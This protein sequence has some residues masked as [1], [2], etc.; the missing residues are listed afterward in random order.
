[1]RIRGSRPSGAGALLA[2]A[3]CAACLFVAAWPVPAAAQADRRAS[4][5]YP[6]DAFLIEYALDHPAQP[7][8][9][10]LEALEVELRVAT[11]G[12]LPPHPATRNERFPLGRV[13]P[14]SRFYSAG[15]TYVAR[16]ILAEFTRRGIDGVLVTFP[17][18]EE[19]SGRD[20][21]AQG[22]RA[23]RVRIWTGRVESVATVAD[24]DRFGDADIEV[25]TNN[26]AH[27]FIREGSPVQ[28]G[29]PKGLLR[30]R[31]IEDYAFQL[32]RHPGRRV[33]ALLK[34]GNLPG[35]TRVDYHVAEDKPWM[36]Y[37][38][39]SNT[40]TR[41]TTR[42]R[43]RFGL[44]T[45]QLTGNDDL[46]RL[47]Y[48]TGN[49]DEVQGVWGQYEAPVWGVPG[50]RIAST[51]SW[52]R[53]DASD[54]GVT[55]LDVQGD[56]WEAGGRLIQ[57]VFQYREL[58][59]D[60]FA[61]ASW[62]NVSVDKNF[63]DDANDPQ[64]GEDDFFLPEVGLRVRRHTDI[65]SLALDV[66][67]DHNL[68]SVAGTEQGNLHLLGTADAEKDFTRILWQGAASIYLEPALRWRR[69]ADPSTPAS[70]T[71]A[72]ELL[73]VTRGQITPGDRLAPQFQQIAGGLYTVRGYDQAVTAGD[74]VLIGSAEYRLHVP[75]LL[76]PD[77]NAPHL[78][79]LGTVKI[80]PEHVYGRP[81]WDF[82]LKAFVDAA[83]VKTQNS[84]DPQISYESNETLI[85]I[86]LGAELQLLK[87]LSVRVDV[88]WPQRGLEN[89]SID[90]PEFHTALTLRY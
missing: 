30:V 9:A 1:M 76:Y 56:Q 19:E 78:P 49:F 39:V 73:L 51:G 81:D 43:E 20:L 80:R 2:A 66:W 27:A 10:E 65:S 7:S 87:Y 41:S 79:V 85:G 61:G 22:V 63:S 71:L 18:I 37:G 69:F 34:P 4:L 53:Y 83:R 28:A 86:G 77:A 31:E 88:G 5:S 72:H 59:V 44:S 45:N 38:Q 12:L 84:H 35:T 25:R 15:L 6:V 50:L 75:R 13:P 42:L 17:D 48:V 58:F 54:V 60:V 62:R 46:L 55:R 57:Q 64:G 40:G 29:G 68:S 24:G 90:R 26:P 70:S 16:Q 74:T 33:D 14:G 47:D 23:L 52:S 67:A 89:A 3:L 32:S 11:G 8:I 21:R 36:L 82:I